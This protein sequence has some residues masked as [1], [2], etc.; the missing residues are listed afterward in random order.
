MTFTSVSWYTHTSLELALPQHSHIQ[1]T[2]LDLGHPRSPQSQGDIK[3]DRV[4][5]R[6]GFQSHMPKP[7][8]AFHLVSTAAKI[9][10]FPRFSR[11]S[12]MLKK[13]KHS[14]NNCKVPK[15]IGTWTQSYQHASH[16]SRGTGKEVASR[17]GDFITGS[18]MPQVPR[19]LLDF[20]LSYFDVF[21]CAG[22]HRTQGLGF[23]PGECCTTELHHQPRVAV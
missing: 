8:P 22:N 13:K 18:A 3:L 2:N 6:K 4:S 20:V 1:L 21:L 5:S 10:Q 17:H 23:L 14:N 11:C 15:R 19:N 7:E 9:V 12:N 16:T